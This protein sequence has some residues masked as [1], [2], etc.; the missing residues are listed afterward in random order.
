MSIRS[1]QGPTTHTH[2]HLEEQIERIKKRCADPNLYLAVVGEFSSGKSTF[3]NALLRDDLLKT[4]P[5]A[6]T[7]SS[8][9][10][11]HGDSLKVQA[12]FKK[13]R[14]GERSHSIKVNG[15]HGR[16]R[17]KWL[18]GAYNMDIR[19][20][21]QATT[22]EEEIASKVS[23]ITIS[24]R[25]SFLADGIVII[26]T[27]GTNAIN[28]RHG[29][30]THRVVENE[31]DAAIIIIPATMLLSQTLA[32]FLTD[33]LR[34]YLHRCLFVVTKMAQIPVQNQDKVLE[35]LRQELSSRL[36]LD[37]PTLYPCSAQ[38]VMD[39]V[40]GE[41]TVKEHLQVWNER[42]TELKTL[43]I[44]RL[45][46]ERAL[47]I[48]ENVTRLL[49]QLFEQLNERLQAQWDQYETNQA[50]IK[51]ETIQDLSSFASNQRR[52]CNS[53]LQKAVSGT[54]LK[55]K[56]LN[57][58]RR[59]ETTSRIRSA[60]FNA[61]S[62]ET[63]NNVINTEVQEYLKKDQERF[64][65]DRGDLRRELGKLAQAVADVGAHF[66]RKFSEAYRRLQILGGRVEARSKSSDDVNPDT[67]EILSSMQSVN[68]GL[69]QQEDGLI[70]GGAAVGATIGTFIFPV[71]GTIAGGLLGGWLGRLFGPSLDERKK[72]L[73]ASL[74]PELNEYFKD[75]VDQGN[76]V[77]GTYEEEV[78]AALQ[79][80]IA[81]YVAKYKSAVTKIRREQETELQRLNSLQSST[82]ADFTEIN[83]RRNALL[84]QQ[85]RMAGIK[86][87]S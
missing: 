26:D 29:E 35:Y 18:P 9:K 83:N 8:T 15:E 23:E 42:F 69:N 51:R 46:Q 65:G 59:E 63:L 79:Q 12:F 5:L 17:A 36:E 11:C 80:R 86:F 85:K 75:T 73:W 10:L 67:S 48:A 70:I 22:S 78:K 44:N 74:A 84:A 1:F 34:P 47:S 3:I 39:N 16:V 19:Q 60:L 52:S 72:R 38:V 25:A 40:T 20:F 32:D 64:R 76:A 30:V 45:R 33:Q 57:Q 54:E 24:H 77:I 21:I 43:V 55:M 14:E 53:M 66:D 49:T 61:G 56:E 58:K 71:V 31:A 81:S 13:S 50:T 4:S 62:V 27:P 41:A 7:A 2:T 68:S 6:T 37:L 28:Q 82:E 87:A